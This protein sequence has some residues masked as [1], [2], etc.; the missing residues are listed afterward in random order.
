MGI[1][2]ESV[3]DLIRKKQIRAVKIGQWKIRPE[4]LEAFIKM[5]RNY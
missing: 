5:R 3:R 1:S 4:D 2:D